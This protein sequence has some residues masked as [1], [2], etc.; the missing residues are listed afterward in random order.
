MTENQ[1]ITVAISAIALLGTVANGFIGAFRQ[2]TEL[3]HNY[4]VLEL[5]T[6]KKYQQEQIQVLSANQDKM[7]KALEICDKQHEETR[8]ELLV[9]K[10]KVNAQPTAVVPVAI[11]PVVP[12]PTPDV[13]G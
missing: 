9:L 1:W 7:A 12:T 10:T 3:Q 13:K 8:I 5:E 4:K 11:A 6:A 2:K